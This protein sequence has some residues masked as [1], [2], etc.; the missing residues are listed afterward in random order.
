MINEET[1]DIPFE[2]GTWRTHHFSAIKIAAVDLDR[3]PECKCTMH[4]R[5]HALHC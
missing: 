1:K 2:P 4:F 5:L 3:H